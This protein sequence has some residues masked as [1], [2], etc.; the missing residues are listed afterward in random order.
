MRIGIV[1][2]GEQALDHL[3]RVELL[4]QGEKGIRI[5]ALLGWCR[6]GAADTDGVALA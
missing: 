6:A 2:E 4:A 1:D 5:V 3:K